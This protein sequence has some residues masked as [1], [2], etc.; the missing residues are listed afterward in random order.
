MS[1]VEPAAIASLSVYAELVVPVKLRAAEVTA[2]AV[3]VV[4]T[5]PGAPVPVALKEN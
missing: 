4:T 1:E 2:A 3:P 5:A